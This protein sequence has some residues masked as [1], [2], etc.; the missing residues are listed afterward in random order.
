MSLAYFHWDPHIEAACRSR[1]SG[2]SPE[3]EPHIRAWHERGWQTD[4]LLEIIAAMTVQ[5]GVHPQCGLRA[6]TKN[7]PISQRGVL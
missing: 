4:P 7:S 2:M 1:V 3:T 5:T 6:P